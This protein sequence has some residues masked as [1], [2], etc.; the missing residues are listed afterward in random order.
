MNF[1]AWSSR[2]LFWLLLKSIQNSYIMDHQQTLIP[3]K[4]HAPYVYLGMRW[5]VEKS[6]RPNTNSNNYT[7]EK[8]CCY[9]CKF[10]LQI[11][12]I[13]KMVVLPLLGQLS[14][15]HGR[16]PLLLI[17]M[18]TTIFSFGKALILLKFIILISHS[19]KSQQKFK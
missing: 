17:T 13:F 15:E 19:L 3:A 4:F 6:V 12:G 11:V 14:D 9:T 5:R 8:T 16:K 2:F 10:V 7:I 1:K 18:S